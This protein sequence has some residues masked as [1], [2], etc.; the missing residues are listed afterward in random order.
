MKAKKRRADGSPCRSDVL[1]RERKGPQEFRWPLGVEKGE[2]NQLFSG[3]FRRSAAWWQLDFG[4]VRRIVDFWPPLPQEY[5]LYCFKLPSLWESYYRSNRKLMH[6]GV[7]AS[8]TPERVMLITCSTGNTNFSEIYE[9]CF[10]FF[11]CG[12]WS[13]LNW[14]S[15]RTS[16]LFSWKYFSSKIFLR[17]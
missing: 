15:L 3:A 4:S 17:F 8:R 11:I 9:K 14:L 1:Y 5:N 6:H 12:T 10:Q 13:W 7:K 2:G 16:I